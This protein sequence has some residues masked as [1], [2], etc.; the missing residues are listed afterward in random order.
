MNSKKFENQIKTMFLK[1]MNRQEKPFSNRLNYSTFGL[2]GT[3]QN[4]NKPTPLM[5]GVGLELQC[6]ENFSNASQFFQLASAI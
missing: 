6:F 5:S 2:A 4:P 1:K 3:V